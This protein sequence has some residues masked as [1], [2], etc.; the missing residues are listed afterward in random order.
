MRN[1]I[2]TAPIRGYK[3]FISPLLGTN[4]RFHPSCSAYARQAIE[5]HGV[6]GI[7][8][9]IKRILRCHPYSRAAMNDPVPE[10]IDRAGFFGYKREVRK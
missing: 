4:C 1:R 9:A 8:L 7:P 2:L 3:F 5:K 10:A 6:R